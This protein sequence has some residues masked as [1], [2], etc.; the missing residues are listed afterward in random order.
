MSDSSGNLYGVT[1]DGGANG[2]GTIFKLTRSSSGTM[3]YGVLYSF[4]GSTPNVP[5]GACPNGTLVVGSDGNLYGTT[6]FGFNDADTVYQ[7]TPSGALT[8]LFYTYN[9][10]SM[11]IGNYPIGRVT[12]DSDGN[13]YAVTGA[14]VFTLAPGGGE[15]NARS[16]YSFGSNGNSKDAGD[17]TSGLITDPNNGIMFGTSHEGGTNG[18]GTVYEVTTGGSEKVLYSFGSA[19]NDGDGGF[20]WAPPLVGKNSMLYGTT[21]LGGKYYV[22]GS[23][24]GGTVFEV[25]E[26]TGQEQV[27]FSFGASGT[28]TSNP[29]PTGS[30]PQGGLIMD[31]NGNLYGTTCEGGYGNNGTVFELT[32]A[33]VET[34][35]YSFSE[36]DGGCPSG[37]LVMG[38][39]G[40]LYGITD[41]GGGNSQGTVFKLTPP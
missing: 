3:T 26:T 39:S 18:A 12:F 21:N 15:A 27:L 19:A 41:Q 22:G 7:I 2:A 14:D 38:P 33:G 23:G 28:S 16:I 11:N 1:C 9:Y 34:I 24:S 20:P 17:I 6:L 8:Q 36:S 29:N 13:L 25:S 10:N 4:P 30:L 40:S 31:A 32:P 35:L 37:Q 5:T